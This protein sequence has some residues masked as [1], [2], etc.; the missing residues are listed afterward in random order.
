[1][2]QTSEMFIKCVLRPSQVGVAHF[3]NVFLVLSSQKN[4]ALALKKWK[5]FFIEE[6]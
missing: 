4:T 2:Q 3:L 1:M 5:M 6:I